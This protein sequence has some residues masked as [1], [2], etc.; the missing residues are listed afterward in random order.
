MGIWVKRKLAGLVA[1]LALLLLMP[2]AGAR[3]LS[4]LARFDPAASDLRARGD[5]VEIVLAISQPVP[6]RVRVL[7]GPPRLVLDVREVDWTGL[8]ALPR[9]RGVVD[10]R[11]GVFR[12]GWSRLVVELAGPMTVVRAGM[13]TG[14][15]TRIR[16]DLDGATPQAFAAAAARPEPPGWALPPP[17]A[18]APQAVGSGPLT[19]V[20]DPGHGGLDPGAERDGAREADLMLTFAREL[21]EALLR[22]GGF[23][24]V[25]TRDEDVFVPLETR[26][27]LARQ[28]GADAFVS[29]HADALAEGEAVGATI[30]TLAEEASDAASAALAER[31]DRDDLLAGVDLTRAD[32]QVAGVL[33]D[34]ART[35]TWPR[36][37]ALAG[38]L[39]AAI[40][41][42]GLT[43]HRVPRQSAAF[44]VLKAPD[45][46][47]VLVELGFLSSAADRARL[48]DPAWRAR[49]AQAMVAGLADWAAQDAA[50]AALRRQ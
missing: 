31:H 1:G 39:M 38:A 40:Q 29:L 42:Q 50:A 46:P 41:R 4:A 18:T 15:A 23:R 22:Q 6:W 20:L 34:I 16:L 9:P 14:E 24:V 44:S 17:A 32:D 26:I 49:M 28:A 10:L 13:E 11:A 27:T 21:K 7:D 37:D 36:T 45:V 48:I 33:M 43:M 47:S 19:V 2:T 12:P 5:G 25:L 3:E 35:E 30:Y 8:A